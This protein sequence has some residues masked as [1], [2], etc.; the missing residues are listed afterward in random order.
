MTVRNQNPHPSLW[1]LGIAIA[2]STAGIAGCDALGDADPRS[3]T[4][5][6][7]TAGDSDCGCGEE[8]D[9]H[10]H[11]TDGDETGDAGTTGG[12]GDGCTLT[13]GYWK[14]HQPWPIADA[15]LCGA[16]WDEI[17]HTAPKGDAWYVVAHQWIAASLNVAS[18]A[19]VTPEVQAALDAAEGYLADCEIADDEKADAL[20]ASALLDDY[21]NGAVGPGHCDDDDGETDGDGETGGDGTTG[22][23]TGTDCIVDCDTGSGTTADWPIP[24]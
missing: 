22:G 17:L 16:T 4:G 2:F 5:V 18:G 3:L 15:G 6:Q 21:N 14:N 7:I 13:Q 10:E 11:E 24:Q 23:D 9:G 19:A 1:T 8:T 20:A 12:D